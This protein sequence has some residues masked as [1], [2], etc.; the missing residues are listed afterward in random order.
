[1]KKN[2]TAAVA[3]AGTNGLLRSSGW[4]LVAAL[5]VAVFAIYRPAWYGGL[6]WDDNAHITAPAL[7]SWQGLARIWLD[8]GATQQYYPLLYSVFWL[9]HWLWGDSTLGYHLVSISLHA[10]AAV[11]LLILLRRL[12]VPGALLAAAVFALHPVQVESV[13]WISEQKNTLSAVFYFGAM[14]CYLG[15]D[16]TRD[17]RRYWLALTLF[18]LGLLSKTVIATLPAALLVIFWWQ[19]GRLSWQTDV[20]PLLPFFVFGIAAGGTTA[21]VERK[22]VGAEGPEFALSLVDRCLIAGRAIWFYLGKI[23][24]PVDLVFVYP[25]WQVS[26]S[27]WWQYLFPLAAVGLLVAVWTLRRRTR[28]PLAALLLFVG[29][30]FPALGFFNVYPFIYSFV[31]D[32]FQYLASAAVITLVAAGVATHLSRAAGLARAVGW[33]ATVAVLAVLGG[34]TSAQSRMYADVETLYR[35]T[36]DRNPGCWMAHYNLGSLLDQHGRL[37]DAIAQY[38]RALAIR[39]GHFNACNNLGMALAQQGQP[40]EALGYFKRAIELK[41]NFADAYYNQGRALAALGQSAGALVSYREALKIDPDFVAARNHLG[42]LLFNRGQVDEAITEYR[43]ALAVGPNSLDAHINL[44]A[45]LA[46]RGQ[47]ADAIREYRRALEIDP[48]SLAAHYNLGGA[49]ASQAMTEEALAQ[50]RDALAVAEQQNQRGLVSA[51]RAKIRML[52][53]EPNAR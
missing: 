6:I 39:P 9:E 42:N 21:W 47:T 48:N 46:R 37:D 13:A 23:F 14:L 28:A 36:I 5:V 29:T 22:L 20:R 38:R 34:L 33:T 11:L 44:G 7:Q 4:L 16:R 53:R 8:I 32:H 10:T 18:V 49:L 17:Q 2:R 25:R 15:F 41:P 1:M 35:T 40:Q 24:W 45:A 26:P 19:R 27:V 52:G 3:N 50:Y 43:R 12:K 51:I 30:L 31:A